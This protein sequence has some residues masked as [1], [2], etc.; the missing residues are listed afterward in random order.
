MRK[1]TLLL[2]V[3][4]LAISSVGA[5]RPDP[6]DPNSV[7]F[8]FDP[9][10]CSGD[11]LGY[12]AVEVNM[13]V[14]STVYAYN[15]GGWRTELDIAMGDGS[16]TDA[17]IT[18]TTARPIKDPNGGWIQE[19]QWGWTAPQE[20]IFY[21]EF[22]LSTQGKPTWKSDIRTI[23][24]YAYVEDQPWL[25]TRDVPFL[26]VG[27][28]QRNWMRSKVLALKFPNKYKAFTSPTHVWK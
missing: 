1:L 20:G 6:L 23:L 21:L 24:V 27:K 22:R 12:V 3:L 8:G 9:N 5:T 14:I 4:F 25:Y 19:F 10:L 26:S 17:V 11:L 15:K 2:I 18:R 7:P 28:F 13:T 16:V